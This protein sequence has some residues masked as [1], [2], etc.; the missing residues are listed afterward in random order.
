[1]PED[2]DPKAAAVWARVSRE[3]GPTG[4]IRGADA[5]ALRIYCESVVRYEEASV[6][7]RH[8]GPL[9]RDH[10]HGGAFV[11]NPLHQIVR[12]NA[13]LVRAMAGELGL[14]P[15]ARVGLQARPERHSAESK[16]DE[17]RARREARGWS[18]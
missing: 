1:M 10:Q 8:S 7:L 15:A 6:T 13:T 9:L 3:F 2:L 4:V 5:D 18:A 14:T 11:K 16:L 12:D 17:L